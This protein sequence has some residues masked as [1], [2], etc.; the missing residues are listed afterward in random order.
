MDSLSISEDEVGAP[1][2]L[3]QNVSSTIKAKHLKDHSKGT[4]LKVGPPAR[5]LLS[6]AGAA[7]SF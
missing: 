6:K 3:T 7:D 1:P 5:S 2:T 4:R